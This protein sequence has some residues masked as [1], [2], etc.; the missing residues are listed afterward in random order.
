MDSIVINTAF[1]PISIID[2]YESFIWTD[3]YYECGDFELYTP[4]VEGIL[5]Y[6][7]QDHYLQSLNS[8]H[9]MIIE[10]IRIDS[11]AEDGSFLTATGRS[12]ESILG[13][14]IVWKQTSISGNFQDGIELLLNENIIDP[15]DTDRKIDN[16][17]F[18]PSD[19]PAITSLT[20]DAQYTGDN[21]YDVIKNACCER[22]VGFKITL[23][24]Y[25]QFVF[26][27]YAGVDRSYDQTK[28]PYVVFSP[29]FDNISNSNYIE[30]KSALK[31][32]ALVAGEGEGPDRKYSSVGG[33]SGL[34]RRELF[35]DARDIT[36]DLG[37][38]VILT[39]DEYTAKLNQRGS[40]K[41]S[42]NKE[43]SSFEGEAETNALYKYGHDFFIGDVV[44]IA[45][46]YGHETT[47]RVVE[48]IMSDN[49]SGSSVYPTFKNTQ[50]GA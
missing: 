39:A 46:E 43:I 44:Q 20:I 30:S 48:M 6:I 45:N 12:L 23:N 13:R 22:N 25:K 32:V 5:E 42:E 36:S 11:D 21:L 18:E 15:S 34:S 9:V 14:R 24:D 27:L 41:L 8:D 38:G 7:K 1:D 28:H 37:D 16:F 2:T 50:E 35:V 4:M 40:E 49:T 26:K 29:K 19:D 10:K 47:A 17:V 31:N 33:G 3:R